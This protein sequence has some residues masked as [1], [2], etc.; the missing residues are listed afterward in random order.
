MCV[1]IIVALM[2]C[3][4]LLLNDGGPAFSSDIELAAPDKESNLRTTPFENMHLLDCV[5]FTLQYMNIWQ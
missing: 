5:A 1:R 3:R 4:I 2:D